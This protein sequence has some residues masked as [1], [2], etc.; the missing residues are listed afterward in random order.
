MIGR[1]STDAPLFPIL[2][3]EAWTTLAGPVQRMH[4]GRASV[5][6]RGSA[7]VTG[8][9]RWPARLLR[10]LLG[11]P[12]PGLVQPV[13]V[14]IARHGND[15]TWTRL[16]AT[17]RMCS[18]LH[19]RGRQLHERLGPVTLRFALH[20]EEG[21]IAWHLMGATAFGL[22]LPRAL[23][24]HVTAYSGAESDRYLFTIEARLPLLGSWIAYRGTLEIV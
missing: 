16:F 1:M 2:L 6:A 15:E 12:Q 17:G 24:G 13:E 10:H 18:R 21:A 22:P 4:G 19:A 5:T 7:D 8:S 14:Q 9:G 11:L 20:A 23:L 3:G